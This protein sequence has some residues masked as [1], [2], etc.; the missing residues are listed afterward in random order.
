MI[1]I[2]KLN[3]E[4]EGLGEGS[5]YHSFIKPYFPKTASLL[6]RKSI[7]KMLKILCSAILK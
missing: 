6:L 1:I 7:F 4:F 3:V 5:E 2:V